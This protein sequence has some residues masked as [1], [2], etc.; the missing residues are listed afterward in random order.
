ME[1]DAEGNIGGV[2]PAGCFGAKGPVCRTRAPKIQQAD[3]RNGITAVGDL[4]I[5]VGS[6]VCVDARDPPRNRA[7]VDPWGGDGAEPV[8][9]LDVSERAGDGNRLRS[10]RGGREERNGAQRQRPDRTQRK[11]KRNRRSG[12]HD[13]V[14]FFETTAAFRIS[15]GSQS[16]GLGGSNDLDAGSMVSKSGKRCRC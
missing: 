12:F 6:I 15:S 11:T 10:Q 7:V 9:S 2:A 16:V 4:E 5:S 1:H 3:Q 8:E 13:T 14:L